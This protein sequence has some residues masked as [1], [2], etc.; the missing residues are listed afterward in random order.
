MNP[1][2][3]QQA[4]EEYIRKDPFAASLGAN[5]EIPAPGRS[6]VSMAVTGEMTNFHGMTHG[7]AVF[8]LSDIAFA[9][10]SNSRGQVAVALNVGITFLKA[11]GPGDRLV[12]EARE[13]HAGGRT[14]LYEIEVRDERTGELVAKSQNLV[15]RKNEW[16]VPEDRSE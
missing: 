12:A 9:A 6:R 4:I 10:A 2:D 11:T 5:V 14:A 16:F 7:G 3:R 15:Y 1:K 13:A 8:A